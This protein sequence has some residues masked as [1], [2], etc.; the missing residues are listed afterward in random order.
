MFHNSLSQD[1]HGRDPY[2]VAL[3]NNNSSVAELLEQFMKRLSDYR[4]VA[5][6]D[7]DHES[8]LYASPTGT[9]CVIKYRVFYNSLFL[10]QRMDTVRLENIGSDRLETVAWIIRQ[11]LQNTRF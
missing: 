1:H 9:G 7:E 8:P 5:A 3:R 11:D 2:R 10:P 6:T 4:A